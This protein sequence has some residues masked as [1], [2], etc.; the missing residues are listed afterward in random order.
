MPG[1]NTKRPWMM[2]ILNV[3]PDSFTDGGKYLAKGAAVV[4]GLEMAEE[5]AD[6]LDVGGESTRPFSETVS[7]DDE[8][9]RVVPVIRELAHKVTIPISIDTTKAEVARQA[10]EAGASWVNDVT[11][12]RG[13]SEMAGVAAHYKVPVILMHMR[14]T[15][16]TMQADPRYEDLFQ[17]IREFFEERMAFAES[18][19]IQREQILLDPGI[20]FGK[21]FGH[22]LSLIKGI[23]RFLT[24]GRPLVLGPSRKAFIGNLVGKDNRFRDEGTAACVAAGVFH[25]VQV[26]RV[27]EVGFMKRVAAVAC[28][29]RDAEI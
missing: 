11:A 26:F 28:A 27:H 9:N 15:P 10:I 18:Q 12:L 2:G 16:E 7:L 19:G 8:I 24:L 14:G 21:T 22:N 5:G 23:S 20:G 13:D 29:L 1:F 3:T 4:R 25:G 6:I 17:E